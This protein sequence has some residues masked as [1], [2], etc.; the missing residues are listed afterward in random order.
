[1]CIRDRYQR[2]VRGGCS[3]KNGVFCVAAGLCLVACLFENKQTQP[4][5]HLACLRTM[6]PKPKEA[7]VVVLGDA[8]VGKTSI[9]QRFIAGSFEDFTK[10]TVGASFAS[11]TVPLESGDNVKLSIWDTAGQE[12]FQSMAPI[13]YRNANAAILIFDLLDMESFGKAK[14][15]IDQLQSNGPPGVAIAIVGNKVDREIER[16]VPSETARGYASE[17]DASY[18]ETSAKTGD[19][20]TELFSYIANVV[21]IN[22]AAMVP[23]AGPSSATV[24]GNNSV[25]QLHMGDD[26]GKKNCCKS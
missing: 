21:D 17:M 1:M 6:P 20:V 14:F 5:C 3:R 26:K 10:A 7:K 22:S 25:M 8:G 11:K 16:K 23:S 4:V 15:W 13:Y 18:F 24:G 2:R 9:I 19:G 12:Q